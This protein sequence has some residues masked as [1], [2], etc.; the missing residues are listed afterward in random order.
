MIVRFISPFFASALSAR[1]SE[2]RSFVAARTQ[3]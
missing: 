3:G 1:S 2:R